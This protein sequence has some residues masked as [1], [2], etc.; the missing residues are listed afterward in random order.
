[1]KGVWWQRDVKK[2]LL[3]EVR[4][5]VELA[6]AGEAQFRLIELRMANVSGGWVCVC[7]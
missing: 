4:S 6:S 3:E 5:G 2:L 7:G 1:M